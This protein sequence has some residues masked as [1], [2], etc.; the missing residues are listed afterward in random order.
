MKLARNNDAKPQAPL[1][2]WAQMDAARS[3]VIPDVSDCFTRG[4][5]AARYHIP[6]STASDQLRLL[7]AGGAVERVTRG[8]Y[9]PRKPN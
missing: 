4:E 1:D 6:P 5:F 8:R 9:R 3:N 7:I 2:L